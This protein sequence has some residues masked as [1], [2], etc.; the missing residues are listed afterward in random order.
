MM[1]KILLF[2]NIFITVLITAQ[3]LSSN[4]NYTYSRTYLEPVTVSQSNAKQIQG[5]QYFDGLGRT[6]QS[7]AIK[8]SPNGKDLIIHSEYD[9]N[10]R[11]TKSYLPLPLDTQNGA[12]QINISSG[13]INSYYGVPNAYSEILLEKS[14]LQ[15]I[16]KSASPGTDWQID[17][18]HTKKTDYRT[19]AENTVKRYRAITTWNPATQLN[20]ISLDI[21][22][23]DGYTTNGFYNINTLFR[24]ISID[25]DG[26]QIETYTNSSKQKILVRQI[27]KKTNGITENLDTYYVYDTY[28]N[29]SFIIPPKASVTSLVP[30]ILDNLCYQYKYDK[31][32]R[33]VEKKLPGTGWIYIVY[34]KQD[35][36]ILVQ[37][38]NLRNTNNNFQNKGWVF[39]KYDKFG[40]VVY[41]GF[42]SNTSTR[43]QMQ[44]EI[45]NMSVNI[46]NN[47]SYSTTP[48]SQ[49]GIDVY[50]SKA[51]FPTGI[52]TILNVNYFD[53]YPVN[54]P[55][56]PPQIKNQTT[57]PSS[58]T[59]YTSN[60]IS[61]IRST[62][63]LPTA[64]YVKNVENDN[65][66]SSFIWY[67]SLGRVIG[68]NNKNHLGGFT[69]IESLLDFSGK[70]IETNTN[71]SKNTSNI[72]F[73]V[74]DRYVYNDHGFIAQHY[75]KINSNSEEL[76][77]DYSYN[78]LGQIINKKVGN[79][80]QN[81]NY[82]YNIRG[83]LTGIN[84]DKI[85]NLGNTLFAYKIKYNS[86]EGV[87]SPNNF[88]SSLKVK[89]KY[90][91]GISETD[92]KTAAGSNEP[93]RRYGYVYDGADRVRAGLFQIDTNPYSKE[94][95]EIIDYDLNGNISSLH[96]T[97]SM[98]NSIA[99]VM[100]DLTYS[101]D[102]NKLSYIEES[103]SGNALS[104]Y[105]LGI[106]QGQTINYDANGNM[107]SHLDKGITSISYNF[108]NLP[109]TIK[110][111]SNSEVKFIYTA[112]GVKARKID[113]SEITDYLGNFQY[114]VSNGVQTSFVLI[115][116]EGYF[117]FVNNRYV[118]QYKDHLGNIRISYTR[119]Q[120]GVAS[121]LEENNYYTFGLKHSGYNIGDIT[122]NKYKPLYNGKELLSNGNLD[123]GWRHYMPDLGRWGNM[124]QFSEAYHSTS[125]YAYVLNNPSNMFD[126]DGRLTQAQIDYIWNNS[127]QGYTSWTFNPDGKSQ[128]EII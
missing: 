45:N 86:V 14:P 60:G 2:I 127:G 110:N 25:E 32:N 11:Q 13:E 15:R 21:A 98:V 119:N 121:I 35:R 85:T 125:P 27:N 40:R 26:N 6:K 92:W 73:N 112:A 37:D 39:T 19:N 4:E 50:Y 58:P 9:N 82:Q 99:E 87:E 61:S 126:P 53:T 47:E 93:L 95:S 120:N 16:E 88:D 36:P 44:T 43:I 80:L 52:M 118:Y 102:G 41:S 74:K 28:G 10:G 105:P 69:N 84:S 100:D 7:I 55:A 29:L 51:A 33:L 90:N 91:G 62:K 54:A 115:N 96:R 22:P 5:V 49:N 97:G 101:Y 109:V 42:F 103:G 67:D 71:H 59:N 117:D 116:E 57:L 81:I 70:I 63:S 64:S 123:Y 122:N 94:Y 1:R 113:N 75:Q 17:G 8:G 77:T 56:Q 68:S 65:W 114:T 23:N 76:L 104:G 46:L 66:S 106:G 83:W 31:Y 78:D 79:N 124:D 89:P 12:Y 34:D 111:T 24:Y 128:S 108:L 30:A 3:N 72:E 20:D 38:A 48:F 107:V 18:N